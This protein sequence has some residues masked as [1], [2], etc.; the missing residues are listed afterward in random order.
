MMHLLPLASPH[1]TQPVR[2]RLQ[3]RE[4]LPVVC[5]NVQDQLH[6]GQRNSSQPLSVSQLLEKY[7]IQPDRVKVVAGRD[8]HPLPMSDEEKKNLIHK[9]MEA[10]QLALKHKEVGNISGDYFSAA[11]QLQ[12]GTWGVGTNIET[13]TQ[14]RS[15]G[16]R[17]SMLVAWNESVHHYT[18]AATPDKSL[19]TPASDGMRVRKIVMSKAQLGEHMVPCSECQG[20]M[21]SQK[22]FSPE[23]Q[24]VTLDKVDSKQ[25][26]SEASPP[27]YELWVRELKDLLPFWGK[28]KPSITEKP[29]ARLEKTF[30]DKA[31]QAFDQKKSQNILNTRTIDQM[32]RKAKRAYEQNE[33]AG[34]TGQRVGA[35]VLL[36]SGH[37][38][39]EGRF[40]WHKRLIEPADFRATA[41]GMTKVKRWRKRLSY[42]WGMMTGWMPK[43]LKSML[44]RG[45]ENL[46]NALERFCPTGLYRYVKMA[47]PPE[48]T[49]QALAY[50]GDIPQEI[51]NIK[52]LGYLAKRNHGGPDTL[53]FTIEDDKV[54]ARTIQDYLAE[55]YISATDKKVPVAF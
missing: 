43:F 12:D 46:S 55:I 28:Q 21:T 1:A 27:D 11:V 6:F 37:I 34:F 23:T 50:F 22:F 48:P 47:F 39:S 18:Q 49:V 45:L 38:V 14:D 30:S 41:Y 2:S 51:P 25:P 29:L 52:S 35:A 20:W 13:S 44:E 42:A 32:L 5:A 10:H 16:E 24:I 3:Q 7:N 33:T 8:K 4:V 31:Q 17:I 15:C 36:S 26:V 40:E 54:Q 53:V 9:A 19:D